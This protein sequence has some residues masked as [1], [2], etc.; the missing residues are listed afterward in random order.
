MKYILF[1]LLIA[2]IPSCADR[3]LKAGESYLM[4]TLATPPAIEAAEYSVNETVRQNI[5]PKVEA[6]RAP[7][8][9]RKLI[10][11]GRINFEVNNVDSTKMSINALVKEIGGYISSEEEN[12]DAMDPQF[13]Q[14]IRV[15]ADK[16]DDFVQQVGR[17]AKRITMKSFSTQ[18]VSEEYVDVEARLV[19]KK[20]LEKNYREILRKARSVK[21][22]LEVER[23]LEDVRGEIESMEGRLQYLK[24]Q[25]A[26]STLTITYFEVAP[27]VDDTTFGD[28]IVQSLGNGWFNVTEFTLDVLSAWPVITVGSIAALILYLRFRS[29]IHRRRTAVPITSNQ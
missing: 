4:D 24:S 29:W 9:N 12:H 6:K 14:V 21:E 20:D 7:V 16:L 25:V 13:E 5:P 3:R 27:V 10:K 11:N 1:L 22:M 18:D 19:T 8:S 2:T 28:R 15:P 23:E 26:F 17:L